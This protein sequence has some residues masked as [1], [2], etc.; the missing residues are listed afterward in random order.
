MPAS[1]VT[2]L[3]GAALLACALPV[4]AKTVSLGADTDSAN[5]AADAMFKE[6]YIDIDE[7]RSTPVRHRYVHGGFKGTDMKFSFYLPPKEQFKGRFFQYVTPVPDSENLAQTVLASDN[8][9]GFAADSGA[10]FVETNGGGTSAT[11]GPAFRTD[12]TIGAYRANAAA[13]RYARVVAGEMYGPRRVYGYIYGGS[14]GAYRTMG[15]MEHTS[16]VWDGAVPFVIGTPMASP[17]NFSIRMHAMRILKDKFPSIVDAMDA[18][19]S[20]DPYAGLNEEEAGALRE[21]SRMG[22]PPNSWFGYKTMGVHAF[23]AVYQG[24]VMADPGYF[25]DFWTKLGYL[26][27]DKPESFANARLQF[28]TKIALP[29]SADDLEA[30]G[31]TPTRLPG[32]PRDAGRGTADMAWQKLVSA[33]TG[34]PLAFEL[35]DLP[36]D[37]NFIG[38]DMYVLS[39][40]AAGKR[41][42]L[43]ALKDKVVTLGV[44]GDLET[45]AKIKPGD[46]VR[47]DNSNFLAAQTYHRHQVPDAS[48]TNYDQFRGPDGK[49][50]YPQRKML[51]GPMFTAGAAGASLSGRFNG[52]IIVVQSGLDREAVPYQADWYSRKFNELYGKEAPNKYRLWFTEN[53]L[54]GYNE[55]KGVSTQVVTYLPMLQQ[56]LRDVSAWVEKGKLPPANAGYQVADGQIV[57]GRTAK[58]R[59]GVQPVITVAAGGAARAQVAVGPLQFTGTISVPPGTGYVVGA[60]WDFDGSG[61][62][63]VKSATSGRRETENVSTS[64]TFTKPGTYF[65]TLRGYAQRK[66]DGTEFAKLRNL[67]RARVVVED[68]DK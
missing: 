15:S 11:A 50:L 16:G 35:A 58:E 9:I 44:V 60:E 30:R 56:A 66:P 28:P 53:A 47:I 2:L 18:G 36:P 67:A 43:L 68:R 14:G 42:A 21:A 52:R 27:F 38:G 4:A 62:Y 13:A 20:G 59:R 29:L 17:N 22:F 1:R 33:G 32:Q 64:H 7:W 19:G 49:P 39:G 57:L 6:P 63:A 3:L 37:K 12:P 61:D 41:I 51:L 45:L 65:V 25:E 10:I 46:D 34:R 5:P 31:L 8:N 54:H 23:T 26:G 48:Y 40:E 24:M 55:D